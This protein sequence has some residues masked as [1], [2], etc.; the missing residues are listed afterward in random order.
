MGKLKASTSK[1]ISV[2]L[3]ILLAFPV[4]FVFGWM[5]LSSFK[6]NQ[7]INQIPPVWLFQPTLN[8]YMNTIRTTSFLRY[9]LNSAIIAFAST[10]IGLSLGLPAAYGLAR[11]LHKGF[12]SLIL[13]ARIFPGVS[14]LVPWFILFLNIGWIGDYRSII[15]AHT[16]IT[17]PLVTWIMIPFFETLPKELEEASLIDGCSRLSSFVKIGL[18]IVKPGIIAATV[19]SF[20]YSWNDFKFSLIL[21]RSRTRTLPVAMQSFIAEAA[22]DW[23]SVMAS[24]TLMILPIIAFVFLT[25]QHIVK[26]LQMGSIK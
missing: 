5:V 4:V 9:F 6:T 11:Y 13:S 16:V 20:I 8:N 22:I 23:G 24:T 21:T 14:Y 1:M 26:G 2:L 19:L 15:L 18:P 12:G 25:Q 17:L 3:V 10:A 7:Q